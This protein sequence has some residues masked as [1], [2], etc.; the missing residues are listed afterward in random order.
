MKESIGRRAEGGR[1]GRGRLRE[2]ERES[3]IEEVITLQFRLPMCQPQSHFTT[4]FNRSSGLVL[5]GLCSSLSPD[6][7]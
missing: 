3:E 1:G 2:G 7:R 5:N 4:S 6:S